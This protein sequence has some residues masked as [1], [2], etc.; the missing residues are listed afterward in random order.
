MTSC[1]NLSTRKVFVDQKAC[2]LMDLCANSLMSIVGLEASRNRKIS[3]SGRYPESEEQHEIVLSSGLPKVLGFAGEE[4]EGF[5]CFKLRRGRKGDGAAESSTEAERVTTRLA[6]YV[7]HCLWQYGHTLAPRGRDML[8]KLVGEVLANAE[9]HSDTRSWWVSGYLRHR[10]EDYGDCHITII[11]FGQTLAQSLQCLPSTSLLR[12]D[13]EGLTSEHTRQGFFHLFGS[14]W[15]QDDLWALYALQEGVSRHNKEA[16][17]IG[18]RGVGT[19]EMIEFFQELGRCHEEGSA[20]KMCVVS[21]RTQFLFDGRYRMKSEPTAA[22]ETRRI[23][24]FNDDN[25][26]QKPPNA[27]CVRRLKRFFPGT[28]ISLRFYL[29]RRHLADMIRKD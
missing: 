3:F 20:P 14:N 7:D 18:G 21:G 28:V 12:R 24:A 29:D 15:T 9:D 2:T 25:D 22:G 27:S 26:L 16:D 6:Q 1:R 19:A 11:N 4:P 8:C 5:L 10:G 13:I 23:I 17:K